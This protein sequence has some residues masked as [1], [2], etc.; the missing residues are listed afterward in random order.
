MPYPAV[1]SQMISLGDRK[2]DYTCC[3]LEAEIIAR[4]ILILSLILDNSNGDNDRL[5]WNIYYHVFVDKESLELLRKQ[6]GKLLGHAASVDEWQNG[7]YGSTIRFCD[8][9]TFDRVLR[10]WKFY[11]IDSTHK[12]EYKKQQQM[13]KFQWKAVQALRREKIGVNGVVLDNLRA[14]FPVRTLD[15]FNNTVEQYKAFWQSGTM[16]KD[17]KVLR[18]MTFANPMF[19]CLRSGLMLHYGI[20]PLGGFHLAPVYARL[21]DESSLNFGN[22]AVNAAMGQ[23]SAWSNAFRTSRHQIALRFVNADAIAFCNVLQH[24]RVHGETAT[25]NWYRT[26]SEYSALV[27]D[28]TDYGN[29]GQAPM[30]FHVIDTSN[31]VDHI[32]SLNILAACSPLLFKQPTSVLRT[33]MLLPREANIMETAELLLCGD[34][35]STALLFGLKP[36]Q[37]WTNANATWRVTDYLLQ[38]SD[39]HADALRKIMSREVILWKPL[40]I[41]GLHYD[42]PN[43]AKFLYGIYIEMF[44]DESWGRKFSVLG[45]QMSRVVDKFK[46][47]DLY[48][49]ASLSTVLCTIRRSGVVEWPKFILTFLDLVLSDQELNMGAHYFQSLVVHAHIL[50]LCNVQQSPWFSPTSFLHDLAKGPFRRWKDVPPVVC[51]TLSVPH[52]ALAPFQSKNVG[53]RICHLGLRSSI[54]PKENFFPDIQLGFGTVTDSGTAFTNDYSI[55]ISDDERGWEGTDPLL[56]SALV[57]VAFL[58]EYGDPACNVLFALKSTLTTT[59]FVPSLGLDLV[60]HKSTVG[61]TDVF[62]TKHRPNM[63]GNISIDCAMVPKE[64]T[65][66]LAHAQI[67]TTGTALIEGLGEALAVQVRPSFNDAAT[68]IMALQAHYDLLSTDLKTCLRDGATIEFVLPEPFILVLKIGGRVVHKMELSLP[69]NEEKGKGKIARKSSWVEYSAPLVGLNGLAARPDMMFPIHMDSRYVLV[70]YVEFRD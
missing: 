2:L 65:G 42:A 50:G 28:T 69:L 44:Q 45:M 48:T 17:K 12:E 67:T 25:A 63:G 33:E 23:F 52:S 59:M 1:H 56:I 20:D 16:I 62:V 21:S 34:L 47:F 57:P 40:E 13:L 49:R 53:S 18:T 22:S 14:T 46:Q 10:L 39:P 51:V 61:Q 60:L 29:D 3:D 55:R 54:T 24:H 6:S 11:S 70:C 35:P 68:K 30:S 37:Y 41:P 43:L 64:T 26:N 4:N 32:G 31:L 58:V 19:A 38:S 36:I 27:L 9:I 8:T 7:P 66:K 15:A 5:I